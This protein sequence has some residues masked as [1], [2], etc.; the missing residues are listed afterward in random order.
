MGINAP[1]RLREQEI[2]VM[3]HSTIEAATTVP[4]MSAPPGS[5]DR[6]ALNKTAGV[7]VYERSSWPFDPADI[8]PLHWWRTMPA[9]HLGDAQH[10]LLRATMEKICIIKEREWLAALHGDAAASIAIAFGALPITEIT[11]EVD[12]AMSALTASALGGNAAATLVLSHIL[13]LAPLDYPFAKELSVSWLVLNLHR[14]LNARA[15]A[16]A[17]CPEAGKRHPVDHRAPFYAGD[18][19]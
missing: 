7:G 13:R 8:S 14:A 19:S 2:F 3:R 4:N 12:L 5:T 6:N 10:L 18:F 17:T 15:A 1:A 11:F 16:A 9:D